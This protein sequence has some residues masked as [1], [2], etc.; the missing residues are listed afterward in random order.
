M[1]PAHDQSALAVMLL[2]CRLLRK[3]D[4]VAGHELPA[5]QPRIT[6]PL[7][8]CVSMVKF[9]M[10]SLPAHCAQKIAFAA[11]IGLRAFYGG[12]STSCWQRHHNRVIGQLVFLK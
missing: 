8:F 5:H 1:L 4:G 12:C 7:C 3:I 6:A 10:R 9:S 11:G 2:P